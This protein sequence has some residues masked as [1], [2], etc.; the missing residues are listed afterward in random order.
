M[1]AVLVAVTNGGD[2]VTTLVGLH[3][4]LQE[5]NP[6]SVAIMNSV[7]LAGW[8]AIK[9]AFSLAA[10]GYCILVRKRWRTMSPLTA[11]LLSLAMGTVLGGIALV[12]GLAVASNLR[13]VLQALSGPG[14]WPGV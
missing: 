3:E 6:I 2:L 1:T 4:G 12:F 5:A 13:F 10:F 14:P 9:C 8:A 7:G 11:V